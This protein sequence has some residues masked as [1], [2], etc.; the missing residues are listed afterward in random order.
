MDSRAKQIERFNALK[1]KALREFERGSLEKALDY[2]YVAATNAWLVHL[3]IWYDDELEHLLFKV[4]SRLHGE[5]G[6][7][8]HVPSRQEQPVKRIAHVAS[9]LPARFLKQNIEIFKEIVDEQSIYLANLPNVPP[10]FLYL[11]ECQK[12][13]IKIR[14]LNY[15]DSYVNRIKE[16]AKLLEED[17]PQMV[18]L[19]IHP[20]DVITLAAISALRKKPYTVFMNHADHAFWLG[21]NVLDLCVEYRRIAAELSVYV[22]KID[23]DKICIIPITTDIKPKRVSRKIYG[24]PESATLSITIGSSYKVLGDPDWNY[25]RAINQILELY[26]AHYHFLVTD[27]NQDSLRK[28]VSDKSDIQKR[29]IIGGPFYDLEPIYGIADFLIETFPLAGGTVRVESIACGLPILAIRNKKSEFYTETDALP[30]NY[31][32]VASTEKEIIDHCRYLIENPDSRKQIGRELYS[33]FIQKMS[34][35][36]VA[37][38]WEKII[39]NQQCDDR[40]KFF[41]SHR[42]SAEKLDD[43]YAYSLRNEFQL[44]KV[45][46]LQALSKRSQFNISDRIKFYIDGFREKEHTGMESFKYL[47]FAIGGFNLASMYSMIRNHVKLGQK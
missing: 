22:R 3:G 5:S 25:F 27:I 31:R 24:I 4:G 9:T 41:D 7:N 47:L 42:F 38:M 8:D 35:Q 11:E 45:L 39:L 34:P 43:Y 19:Y 15:Q 2:A 14:Q 30:A 33:H 29:F 12:I 13:G 18:V 23:P 26:P 46:L 28:L 37:D 32:Y 20:G 36:V 1:L 21:R 44:H 17:S 10:E 40:C 16:F 6:T